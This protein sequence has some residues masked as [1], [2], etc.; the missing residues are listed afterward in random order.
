MSYCNTSDLPVMEYVLAYSWA[1]K[2]SILNVTKW[3][4]PGKPSDYL[5]AYPEIPI[6]GK[7]ALAAVFGESHYLVIGLAMLRDIPR[8]VMMHITPRRT[9]G[10]LSTIADPCL[11]LF[12]NYYQGFIKLSSGPLEV[13]QVGMLW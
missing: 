12:H 13:K 4:G 11:R 2:Y 5:I 1:S 9:P 6:G 10:I 3:G 7:G 8:T